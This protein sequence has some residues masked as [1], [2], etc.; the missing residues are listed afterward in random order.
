VRGKADGEYD[1]D[2]GRVESHTFLK[3]VEFES[4]KKRKVSKENKGFMEGWKKV[5]EEGKEQLRGLL[6]EGETASYVTRDLQC[7]ERLRIWC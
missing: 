4:M 6:E 1:K 2:V 3:L 5:V 7:V